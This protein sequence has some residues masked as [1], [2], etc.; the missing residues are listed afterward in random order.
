MWLMAAVLDSAVEWWKASECFPAELQD[1][2][3]QLAV[4]K[5]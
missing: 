5:K 4:M 3:E 1:P 2:K